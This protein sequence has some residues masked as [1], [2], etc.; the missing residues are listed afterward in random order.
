MPHITVYTLKQPDINKKRQLVEKLTDA[1][2][3]VYGVPREAVTVEILENEP[4]NVAHGG[5][6]IFDRDS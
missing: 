5:Q 1:A 4:E 2:V 3:E 6:L